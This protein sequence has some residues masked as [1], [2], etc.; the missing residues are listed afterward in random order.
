[1]GDS[2]QRLKRKRPGNASPARSSRWE[3]PPPLVPGYSP[4][5][6]DSARI[7]RRLT[8]ELPFDPVSFLVTCRSHLRSTGSFRMEENL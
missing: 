6:K 7:T 1:M 8:G 4:W 3:I 2:L 5:R